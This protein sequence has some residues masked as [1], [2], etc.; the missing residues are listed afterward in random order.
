MR[1]RDVQ[2]MRVLES[3]HVWYSFGPRPELDQVLQNKREALKFL[4]SYAFGGR[5]GAPKSYWTVALYCVEQHYKGDNPKDEAA[6][7]WS[8]FE[9]RVSST[10]PDRNP[11]NAASTERKGPAVLLFDFNHVHSLLNQG[12]T[13]EAFCHL[14]SIRG[15]GT[16]I[17]AF[18]LRDVADFYGPYKRSW[19]GEQSAYM[20][21]IDIWLETIVGILGI[22]AGA[23]PPAELRHALYEDGAKTDA[24]WAVTN[25]CS[26]KAINPLHFNQGAWYFASAI[27]GTEQHLRF[28]LDSGR[29]GMVDAAVNMLPYLNLPAS[30]AAELHRALPAP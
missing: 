26:E 1:S 22:A 9:R 16:K 27:A 5:A 8:E 7:I 15:I 4:L 3:F 2:A 29:D 10:N 19:S 6:R 18:I 28:L 13:R 24:A 20:Q 23:P 17:A 30:A 21:P 14:R 11:L 25:V 12:K